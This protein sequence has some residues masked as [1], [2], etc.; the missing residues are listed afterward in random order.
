MPGQA[1]HSSQQS[2][3]ARGSRLPLAPEAV[4]ALRIGE[5]KPTHL[6]LPTR[7]TLHTMTASSDVM[8]FKLDDGK[9]VAQSAAPSRRIHNLADLEEAHRAGII[10]ELTKLN[11]QHRLRQY[12][13]LWDTVR[14]MKQTLG[15]PDDIVLYYYEKCRLVHP[16]VTDCVGIKHDDIM[17]DINTQLMSQ[18]LSQRASNHASPAAFHASSGSSSTK[19][20]GQRTR[21]CMPYNDRLCTAD[22][23]SCP[24]R[25]PH[26][27]CRCGG[28]HASSTPGACAMPDPRTQPGYKPRGNRGNQGRGGGAG[29]GTGAGG[30]P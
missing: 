12:A 10:E 7:L 13:M 16:G 2:F 24:R 27:C 25:L 15:Y 30:R 6:Y 1:S 11:D 8:K 4:N 22:A 9:L 18:S 28:N 3:L 5:Y 17:Q 21:V 20:A 14:H 23:G 19:P 26:V 29:A